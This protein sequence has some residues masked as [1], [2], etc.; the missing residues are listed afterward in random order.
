VTE[1]RSGRTKRPARARGFV[2]LVGAGP[3]DPELLTVRARHRLEAAELVL[4]D[5]LVPRAIV[6]VAKGAKRVSVA[7]RVGPKARTQEEVDDLI[8]AGARA[9][10][11][12]VRL[13]AGDPFV[14]ARGGEEVQ[15]LIA[16]DV[17]FEIVPGISTAFAAPAA[18]GIPVTHRGLAA[19]VVVVSGH[20]PD[21]YEPVLS[22]IPP[23]SATVVV[24]M[25][26]GRRRAIAQCLRRA[27]W[28]KTTP[29]AIVISA[30]QPRQRVWRGVLGALGVTD[31]IESSEEPG[32]IVIGDVAGL[33]QRKRKRKEG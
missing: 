10:L 9:G 24:L 2:S 26:L 27:G 6:N 17:P 29:V 4:F 28:K 7:K 14:L 32:V 31:P 20:G 18:A 33:F 8:I 16:A 22:R 21:V 30:S 13:K 11:R 3:G 5:G 25:G 15:A 12:V 23:G 1:A 19:G